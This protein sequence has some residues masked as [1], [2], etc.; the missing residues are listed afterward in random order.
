MRPRHIILD[1]PTAQ[2]DPLGT[3]LVG[4]ALRHLAETGTSLL[5]AEHKTDLLEGLCSRV[6]VIDDGRIVRDGPADDVLADE[7]LTEL[8]VEPPSRI[9]I[10]RAVRA[11]GLEPAALSTARTAR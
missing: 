4:D 10:E 2:L 5:I 6:V 9:R 8:G 11:A 1:E 7:W 3:G